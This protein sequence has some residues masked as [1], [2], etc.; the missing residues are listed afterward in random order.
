MI[1]IKENL[2]KKRQTWKTDN[3]YRKVW[4]FVDTVWLDHHLDL[5]NQVVPNYVLDSGYDD[6]SMW[7]DYNIIPGITA[8]KFEHTDDFIKNI[9]AFCLR[10]IEETKPYVHGDWVLSNIIIDG[11]NIQMCDWDN[12]NIYPRDEILKKLHKDLESAFGKKFN[13]VIK[14]DSASI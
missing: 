7:I 3:F 10:N 13:E 4:L 11:E 9:Y 14:D 5:L 8:S 2:Q 12:L 6:K 1:L